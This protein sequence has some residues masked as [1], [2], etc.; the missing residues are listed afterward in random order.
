MR[1]SEPPNCF[2]NISMTLCRRLKSWRTGV[3]RN[4]LAFKRRILR[5]GIQHDFICLPVQEQRGCCCACKDTHVRHPIRRGL[6]DPQPPTGRKRAK[7]IARRLNPN[8]KP[9]ALLAAYPRRCC[10]I[11]GGSSVCS[12]D[13]SAA[14]R[15]EAAPTVLCWVPLLIFSSRGEI[16]KCLLPCC[17][18]AR[19]PAH[20][21]THGRRLNPKSALFG[22]RNFRF[23]EV[24]TSR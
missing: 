8:S 22:F 5:V 2:S 17:G 3:R 18:T 12:R 14:S 16:H 23:P 6:S 10:K 4:G 13:R 11:S 15:C 21:L 9:P 1:G 20:G 7:E 19:T 24:S